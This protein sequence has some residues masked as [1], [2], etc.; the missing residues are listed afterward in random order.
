[1]PWTSNHIGKWREIGFQYERLPNLCYWRGRL[2]HDDKQCELWIWSRILILFPFQN[3]HQRLNWKEW[4]KRKFLLIIKAQIRILF[5]LIIRYLLSMKINLFHSQLDQM[6]AHG[7]LL[8]GVTFLIQAPSLTWIIRRSSNAITCRILCSVM[9]PLKPKPKRRP[10]RITPLLLQPVTCPLICCNKTKP[11][12]Q[13]QGKWSRLLK[14]Q[15]APSSQHDY[16]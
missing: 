11:P 2:A 14:A 15:R 16:G 7:A 8:L 3:S 6:S 5:S 13:I 10:Q 9:W 12:I 4:L 1:M